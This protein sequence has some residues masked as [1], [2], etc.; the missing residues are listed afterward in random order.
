MAA[1][2]HGLL[3]K[4]AIKGTARS[5]GYDATFMARPF[6][7][8]SGNGLHLHISFAQP[9][10]REKYLRNEHRTGGQGVEEGKGKGFGWDLECVTIAGD[11]TDGCFQ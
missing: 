4:R 9:H 1:A 8:I 11:G 7:G 10:F 5:L 3:L 2:D 6:E